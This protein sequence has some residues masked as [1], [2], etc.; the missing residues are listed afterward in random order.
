MRF[1]PFL[2]PVAGL[3]FISLLSGCGGGYSSQ[4]PSPIPS[5]TPS[6]APT[7]VAL[8]TVVSGLV[9]SV[10]LQT[11]DDN[12]GRLFVVEPPGTI[13]ISSKV[14]LLPTNVLDSSSKVHFVCER[15]HLGH[16]FN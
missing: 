7:A 15:G 4:S 1:Y 16:S 9:S 12:S 13:R 6:P 14:A 11:P 2:H 10:D 5:P 8:T 3:L